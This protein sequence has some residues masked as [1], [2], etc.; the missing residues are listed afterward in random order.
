MRKLFIDCQ[1]LQTAAFER[2]MGKYSL[3]LLKALTRNKQFTD[4]TQPVLIFNDNLPLDADKLKAIADYIDVSNIVKVDL[5]IDIGTS[6]MEKYEEAIAK[7][8]RSISEQLE[9]GESA[10]YLIM[11]PFFV[12][13][14]AVFPQLPNIRKLTLVYDLIP[15]LIWQKQKIFPDDVYSQHFKLFLQADHIFSISEAVRADLINILGISSNIITNINGGPFERIGSTDATI[16]VP[17]PYV[18]YPSGPIVHKNNH[19]AVAGFMLFNKKH[20]NRYT[21]VFTS[22]FDSET[23]DALKKMSPSVMFTGNVSDAQLAGIYKGSEV[24]LF[25]SLAEGLGMPVLEAAAYDKP[26]A[27]SNIDVLTEMSRGAFYVF[28]PLQPQSIA[29]ALARAV[30]GD[31]WQLKQSQYKVLAKK[32]QWSNSAQSVV[33][34]LREPV[35]E[36]VV[37]TKPKLLVLAPN[38]GY[39]NAISR[40]IEKSY[41]QLTKTYEV[42]FRYYAG[43]GKRLFSYVEYLALQ[44]D[45]TAGIDKAL[46]FVDTRSRIPFKQPKA[47]PTLVVSINSGCES[48]GIFSRLTKRT[49]PDL[50]I[51]AEPLLLNEAL[52]LPGWKY[53]TRS[54]ES[55]L[56]VIESALQ[57]VG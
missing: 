56:P 16:E 7:L 34:V 35:P 18:V 10:S 3:S 51:T 9:S 23:Q 25:A 47:V 49:T 33:D 17:N 39:D 22:N 45:D 21:L 28:D 37:K 1:I 14:P 27:C 20:D 50:L 36:Q 38:P 2:G 29:E 42:R 57:K 4:D 43:S 24:V 52:G 54:G 19:N 40:F 12:T 8:T 15:Y 41:A 55:V 31:D 53:Q 32:Y 11:S 44:Q 6:V 26:I 46:C 5:P 48:R 30:D 13:F